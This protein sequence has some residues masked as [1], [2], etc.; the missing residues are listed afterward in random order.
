[1]SPPTSSPPSPHPVTE[2]SVSGPTVLFTLSGADR[3]GV[4]RTLFGALAHYPLIVVD[5]EQVVIRGQLI[6]ATLLA[7]EPSANGDTFVAAIE[8]SQRVAAELDMVIDVVHGE[9][10]PGSLVSNRVHVTLLGAPL[11]PVALSTITAQDA[12]DFFEHEFF[13]PHYRETRLEVMR[14]LHDDPEGGGN[15]GRRD[16]RR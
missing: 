1:M 7:A 13:S 15:A 16:Q 2:V 8:T 6:L 10:D 5:V 14:R 12:R 3:P 11:R 9:G 4:S